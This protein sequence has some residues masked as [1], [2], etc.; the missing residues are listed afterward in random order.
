MIAFNASKKVIVKPILQTSLLS[1]HLFYIDFRKR[2]YLDRGF[3][4]KQGDI[5]R[6]FVGST[7]VKYAL[8]K[9]ISEAN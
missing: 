9:I 4:L 8:E 5:L 2:L 1:I 7:N 6:T 3:K